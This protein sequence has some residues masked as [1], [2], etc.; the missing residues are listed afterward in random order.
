MRQRRH[1]ETIEEICVQVLV[2]RGV[3]A[4]QDVQHRN[5]DFEVAAGASKP[6]EVMESQDLG[7]RLPKNV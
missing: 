3:Y 5:P 7:F 6:A 2:R 1:P 4:N